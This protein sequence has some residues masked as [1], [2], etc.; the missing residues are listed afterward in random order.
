[1]R[2]CTNSIRLSLGKQPTAGDPMP[3]NIAYS[4]FRGLILIVLLIGVSSVSAQDDMIWNSVDPD[5][6]VYLQMKEGTVVIEL[7]P[8]FAPKTV[9]R[10]KQ[11]LEEQFYRSLSFYRVIDGFVA[12]GGD[13]SDIDDNPAIKTL[14]SRV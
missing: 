12:Q 3:N 4:V 2:H 9:K 8:A 11:L 14:K 6:T 10:F 1:M 5:N 7:N 13:E